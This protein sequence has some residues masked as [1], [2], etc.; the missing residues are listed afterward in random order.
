MLTATIDN[1]YQAMIDAK[2]EVFNHESDLYVFVNDV[3]T[4]LVNQYTFK[5]NV[6]TFTDNVTGKL[7]YDIPFAFVPYWTAKR[8]QPVKHVCGDK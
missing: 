6:R 8:R 4:K 3:T 1:I 7:M 5:Q 2:Q